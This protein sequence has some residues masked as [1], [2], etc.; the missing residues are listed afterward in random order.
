[1]EIIEIK[2]MK[3]FLPLRFPERRY[4]RPTYHSNGRFEK[5]LNAAT[6]D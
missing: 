2:E 6:P 3:R 4:R 5:N 1:M